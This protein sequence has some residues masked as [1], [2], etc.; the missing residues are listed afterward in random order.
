MQTALVSNYRRWKA[1]F[2]AKGLPVEDFSP[3]LLLQ[4][5]DHYCAAPLK[6]VVYGQE[7]AGW[8]WTRDLQRTFPAYPKN[9]PFHDLRT[10]QDF[11]KND[12]AIEGLLWGYEQFAFAKHQPPLNY[13]SPFWRAFREIQGWQDA[14]V[15]WA[16]LIRMDYKGASI[17]NADVKMQQA[18]LR[19]QNKVLQEELEVLRPNACIFL[20]G[21]NYD[22]AL[23]AAFPQLEFKR[24][25]DTPE[26]ELARLV[27]SDLPANSYRTYH[28]KYLSQ[29]R[30]WGYLEVMRRLV[31]QRDAQ[32]AE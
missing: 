17:F 29:G 28:P 3:P 10:F 23:K 22:D 15:M 4:P 8:D 14:G 20:T 1:S 9:W 2:D 21:P 7:T 26:R 31:I 6:I 5:T 11:L 13:R 27:H 18:M 32:A 25:D 12:D 30:R 24:V 19:Q 16:N